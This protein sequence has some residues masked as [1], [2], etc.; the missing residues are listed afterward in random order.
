MPSDTSRNGQSSN[1]YHCRRFLRS[2]SA[3][4]IT[5]ETAILFMLSS[6]NLAHT[7]NQRYRTYLFYP[8]RIFLTRGCKSVTYIV[9]CLRRFYQPQDFE[10]CLRLLGSFFQY[11]SYIFVIFPFGFVL[12]LG[13]LIFWKLP[14]QIC[15]RPGCRLY[16]LDS[17]KLL[18]IQQDCLRNDYSSSNIQ[19]LYR[20]WFSDIMVWLQ[21]L[22]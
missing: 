18:S 5:R 11:I 7:K 2:F 17:W 15:H 3:V 22:L 19:K 1:Y 6:L 14:K 16:R 13:C 10:S 9:C 20:S 21:N 12:C 4:D 8:T